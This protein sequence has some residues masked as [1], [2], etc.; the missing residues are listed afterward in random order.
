MTD[1]PRPPL[2]T[3]TSI[4]PAAFVLL[5]G[6]GMLVVFMI[7]NVVTDS[8][9]ATTTT[10]PIVVGGLTTQTGAGSGDALLSN[11]HQDGE[12]PANIYS[13]FVLPSRRDQMAPSPCPTAAPVTLTA[14]VPLSQRRRIRGSSATTPT[15]SKRGA[16]TSSP[17]GPPTA[18]PSCSSK[19]RA[20]TPSTGYW[21]SPL[22]PATA[23]PW[24]GPTV[25]IRTRPRFRRARPTPAPR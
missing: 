9:V 10:I 7:L 11:C 13:A 16:G 25:F 22:T 12:P 3:T 6:A 2:T 15:S 8:P 5:L 18:T 14:T 23:T 24:T 20:A 1:S 19:K 21:V 4:W 17:P